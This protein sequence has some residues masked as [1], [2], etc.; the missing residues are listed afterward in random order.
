MSRCSG[1]EKP[2]L[3]RG[4]RFF[5]DCEMSEETITPNEYQ[6]RLLIYVVWHPAFERGQ[7]LAENIYVHFSRDPGGRMRGELAFLFSFDPRQALEG[8]RRPHQSPS[9]PRSTRPPL[10]WSIRRWLLPT[11]GISMSKT[12][13]TKRVRHHTGIGFSPSRLTTPRIN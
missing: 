11:A 5:L 6:P 9:M 2:P 8:R 1:G 10:C 12:Y 13:G 4:V 3:F 7:E